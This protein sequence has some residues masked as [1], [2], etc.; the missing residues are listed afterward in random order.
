M[1]QEKGIASN[2]LQFTLV[3]KPVAETE[4]AACTPA[5][6]CAP[7]TVGSSDG[8]VKRKFDD[9]EGVEPPLNVS[10]QIKNIYV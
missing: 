4:P 3:T 2:P 10:Y 8:S 5:A 6:T 1:E 7:A 9:H